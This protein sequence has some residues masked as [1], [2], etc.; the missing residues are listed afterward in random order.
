MS[1]GRKEAA[2]HQAAGKKG[3]GLA[4]KLLS[5]IAVLVVVAG[6]VSAIGFRSL[7][8]TIDGFGEQA[9]YTERSFMVGR[10]TTNL[11]AYA[12]AVEW[13]PVELSPDQRRHWETSIADERRGLNDRLDRLA[14]T[15]VIPENRARLEQTRE[16]L[17]RYRGVEERVLEL[18]RA[19]QLKEAGDAAVAGAPA[20]DRARQLMRE[21]EE[22]ASAVGEA[23]AERTRL[24]AVGAEKLLI[25]APAIGI[26][27]GLGI[28]MLIVL[29]GVTGPLRRLSGQASRLAEGQLDHLAEGAERGDEVG[30]IARGLE[31]LRL[32]AQRARQL[33]AEVEQARAQAAEDRRTAMLGLADS[34]ESSVGGVIGIVASASTELEQTARQM[35][36]SAKEAGT[37]AGEAAQGTE[38]ASQGVNTVAA[39]AEELS[40]SISEI[41]RQVSQSATVARQAVEEAKRTDSTVEALAAS[42]A[43]I[44]EVVRLISDIA[45]QTNLL[46]LNATIEA[47]RAGEA[48]KGFAVVA[49]EV[50]A[51]ASQ[52]AKATEEIGRQIAEMRGAT[53]GAVTAVR[54]IATT[55]A[56]IDEIASAIAAAVEEQGAATREISGSVQRAAQGTA[57][58]TESVAGVDRAAN[59]T[60]AAATQVLAAAGELS[61]QAEGLRTEVGR[62]LNTVRAG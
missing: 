11:L 20:I 35:S 23:A 27:L 37:K 39:A 50:K 47:A 15:I 26:P 45:G 36:V 42:A 13:L 52:T 3:L 40:A 9:G 46:A 49:G 18:S 8:Q 4:P 57:R 38:T 19:G 60:G 41:S 56:R 51:L 54:G 12:R 14:S 10:A 1:H 16:L 59:D 33:E 62:F 44:G 61:R 17:N 58:V 34:F 32:A 43:R 29:R 31:T 7:E 53:D 24:A 55:I 5:A 48:G 22:A 30:E 21:I 25:A 6:L 2:T 28:A